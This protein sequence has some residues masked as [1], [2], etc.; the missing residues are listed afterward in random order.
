MGCYFTR[1][2][3]ADND[4]QIFI[5]FIHGQQFFQPA[6][7][8]GLVDPRQ[9]AKL[10]ENGMQRRRESFEQRIDEAYALFSGQLKGFGIFLDQKV[11]T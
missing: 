1:P 5:F 7:D 11:Q 10:L 4:E 2:R 8:I 6:F 9:S 3:V